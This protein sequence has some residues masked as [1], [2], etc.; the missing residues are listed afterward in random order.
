MS[1][2]P[3]PFAFVLMPFSP[4]FDEAYKLAIKPACDAAGAYA[5][6]VDEQIFSGSILERIYNQI[7]K[8]DVVIAEMS[9]RNPNVFYEVGYAHAIG[10]T[11]VLITRSAADIPFDLKHFPHIV[12]EDSLAT[13]RERLEGTVR[14]HLQNAPVVDQA[15]ADVRIRVN[16]VQL[17]NAT[18]VEVVLNGGAFGMQLSVEV[19]NHAGRTISTVEGRL[20]LLY[21]SE[22]MAIDQVANYGTTGVQLDGG[23]RLCL[24]GQRVSLLP[25][26]WWSERIPLTRPNHPFQANEAIPITIRLLRPSGIRDFPFTLHVTHK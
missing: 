18:V 2:A 12:Y 1:T 21:P 15:I 4:A 20:G 22:F 6:R 17:G 3:K 23:T 24:V 13:L 11:T 16:G 14:W 19:E 5:E 9:E 8:S 25:G 10:K 26:E 7:A